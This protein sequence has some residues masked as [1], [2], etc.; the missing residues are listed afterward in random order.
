MRQPYARLVDLAAV[1][2]DVGEP[3]GQGR[4][5]D[6]GEQAAEE[7]LV[8]LGRHAQARLGD[9]FAVRL[10]R[11]Q[12]LAAPLQQGADLVVQNL[13]GRVVADQ[14]V[15]QRQQQ[16]PLL[17]GVEGDDEAQQ[18]GPAK[19]DAVMAR[20]EAAPELLG[21]GALLGIEAELCDAQL[22]LAPDHL[23]G[24]GETLPEEGGA[25]DVVPRDDLL[26]SVKITVQEGP[27]GE[28]DQAG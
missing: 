12:A 7:R 10:G 28:G 25:Q 5:V 22:G 3:E 2:M 18:R 21:R 8:L 19:L 13:Q 27:I 26:E 14:V 23:D 6:V 16:P 15:P 20:I 17:F 1:A 4:L 24:A 11:R 9:Q